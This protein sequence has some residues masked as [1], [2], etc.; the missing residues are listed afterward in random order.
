MRWF[1]FYSEVLDDP[2]VQRLDPVTFKH[3][4][5]MLCLAS[6][7]DGRLPKNDDLAFALRV[8]IV[9]LETV[10][11]RLLN[12]TLID[13]CNGGVNGRHIAMHNWDERQ[14]KSD[15]STDRVK[16]FRQR[17]RNVTET[18]PDTDTDTDTEKGKARA[19]KAEKT[20]GFPK[21]DWAEQSV[22]NDLLANRFVE[23]VESM[24]SAGWP[25]AKLLEAIVAKGWGG[26]YDPRDNVGHGQANQRPAT[27]A[28]YLDYVS[29]R[30]DIG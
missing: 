4:V 24:T 3:W 30:R 20:G 8:D 28:S 6:K 23:T 26:A 21:P 15:T 16:R 17:S 25:P 12:A 2:K 27:P 1:R 13:L 19:P 7:H 29:A 18:G 14:Y 5:N 10:L 22:W 11:E 9:T